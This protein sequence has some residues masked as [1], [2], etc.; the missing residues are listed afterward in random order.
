MLR[1]A[2]AL[3]RIGVRWAP[4]NALRT[5]GFQDWLYE[6]IFRWNDSFMADVLYTILILLSV[7]LVSFLISYILKMV[8]KSV[9]SIIG[10]IKKSA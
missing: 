10:N 4:Q 1:T 9:E 7:F 2:S 5:H 6:L 8:K 3:K